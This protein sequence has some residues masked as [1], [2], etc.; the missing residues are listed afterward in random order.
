MA[1]KRAFTQ[2]KQQA[3]TKHD[4]SSAT[5]FD[6]RVVGLCA[7]ANDSPYVF[8]TS[9][10]SGRHLLW[11][12]EG[13]KATQSFA[14][15]R[16]S[17][18][19]AD[20]AYFLDHDANDQAPFR[21]APLDAAPDSEGA[22]W[23]RYEPLI[24]HA[25]C[26]DAEAAQAFMRAARTVFKNVGLQS[27]AFE[28]DGACVA[29]VGDEGLDM[30]LR[31]PDGEALF[32]VQHV[33]WLVATLN[34][35]HERNWAK[36]AR[37]EAAL[38]A[39]LEELAADRAH[40]DDDDDALKPRRARYDVVGDVAVLRRPVLPDED[41]AALAARVLG[42]NGKLRVVVAPPAGAQLA[43]AHRSPATALVCLG[44]RD[45]RPLVT[46]HN[47]HG[48]SVVVDL[49]AC[50]FTPRLATERLRVAR[51]VARDERVLCLF[52][53]CGAEALIIAATT[54]CSKVACVEVN[55][56][57]TRC[58]ERSVQTLRRSKGD[59][60][61]DRVEV[62]CA[63]VLDD[64]AARARRG[65]TFDR[66]LAPRPKGKRDGDRVDGAAADDDGADGGGGPDGIRFLEAILPVLTPT[67][68]V[69]WT[70]FAADHELPACERTRTFLTE[71]CAR[72][73]GAPCHVLHSAKAGSSSV[74]ARQ[75]RVTVDFR[76]ADIGPRGASVHP[77]GLPLR[78]SQ[79]TR[80]ASSVV[81]DEE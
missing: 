51:A 58:L 44:G 70:D 5:S 16:V 10:C 28:T 34:E 2:A 29:V 24:L 39:V 77:A 33:P 32:G 27:A 63:D 62:V 48:V 69:H 79:K 30:P 37:F 23:L 67:A 56:V 35:K 50:F 36:T 57:A 18:D 3:L 47:E 15:G 38:R 76:L 68:V 31:S 55:P 4:K 60:A 45:R 53:G 52:A 17:H 46:T 42:S 78:G 61:A 49:N 71:A 74:A 43:G 66:V 21:K 19:R 8:T 54:A 40:G 81:G 11:R 64:L 1:P 73:V 14:R 9:S 22:L 72:L 13:V 6:A 80:P 41:A 12:G 75:Y 26:A 65:E 25:R 20:A 7:A 59:A